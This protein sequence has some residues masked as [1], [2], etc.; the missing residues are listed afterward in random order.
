VHDAFGV[1][2]YTVGFAAHGGQFG[3]FGRKSP[4]SPPKDGSFED[5]LHRYVGPLSPA[6]AAVFVDLRREG[7]FSKPTQLGVL[8]YARDMTAKWGEV[9]DGVVFIDEMTPAK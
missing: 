9:V 3:T 7:P 8:A 4:L 2:C 1:Q 5:L 6:P